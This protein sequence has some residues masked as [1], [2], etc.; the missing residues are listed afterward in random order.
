MR[1]SVAMK[2]TIWFS[3]LLG[4]A[5]ACGGG[6]GTGADAGPSGDGGAPADGAPVDGPPSCAGVDCSGH[7]TCAVVRGEASCA[8]DA[9]YVHDG[10]VACV[11]TTA[12]VLGGCQVLPSDH[13][14]NTPIDQLPVDP[15]SAAYVATIGAT[16]RVHLDLGTTTDP[17]SATYYGIPHNLVHADAIPWATVHYHSADPSI[18]WDARAEADCV[19]AS[20]GAAHAI[21]SPC[22]AAAAPNPRLPIPASPLVEGGIDPNPAQP[23]GDHH[24][25]ML[26]VDHCRLWETYH[27][28]P[29]AG[30][31]DIYG[32]ATFD[33]SSNALRP[34]GWT[35]EDAAGFPILPLVLRGAEA[36]TGAI[37]HALRFTIQSSKIRIGY[38]WPARHLTSNGTTSTNLPP[39]GQLFRLKAGYAIP[40]DATPR[41]R[42]I[43]TALKTYGMYLAD[44][45]SDMFI[46]GDPDAGWDDTTLGQV[47]KVTAA[48]FE[49]VDLTP[50]QR[51][52][53]FDPNSAAVPPP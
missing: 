26:D 11:A 48:D 24:I 2:H 36:Q 37:R 6:E 20:S 46:T 43:L 21:V 27:S 34:D 38:T 16:R 53:G 5:G 29:V 52:A 45:G 40:T 28:F 47:Q 49:A 4:V 13:V 23:Y 18:S 31:W 51:R 19:D 10:P 3:L 14:F 50:I 42:A 7:G 15:R 32:S 12:P 30:G 39:M 41:T 1:R 25:L 22:T 33:L 44:G 8:C 17:T 35:S 9:G